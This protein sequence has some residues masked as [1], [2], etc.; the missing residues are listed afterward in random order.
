MADWAEWQ[1]F[2]IF[3]KKNMTIRSKRARE[4]GGKKAAGAFLFAFLL[5]EVLALFIETKGDFANGILDFLRAQV[6]AFFLSLTLVMFITLF[7]LG[8]MAGKQILY[9]KKNHV[10]VGLMY[11]FFAIAIVLAYAVGCVFILG[12][13]MDYWIPFI[14]FLSLFILAICAWAAWRMERA[15]L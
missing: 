12:I 9:D 1:K 13:V 14:I 4:I 8:R 7:F 10:Y 11:A 6:D 2:I 15:G 5:F 3:W